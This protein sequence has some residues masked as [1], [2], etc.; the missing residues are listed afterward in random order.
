MF[1]NDLHDMSHRELV[2]MLIALRRHVED[3]TWR[4]EDAELIV[5]IREELGLRGFT[6]QELIELLDDPAELPLSKAAD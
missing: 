6:S 2:A 5:E 4:V 1:E 3:A